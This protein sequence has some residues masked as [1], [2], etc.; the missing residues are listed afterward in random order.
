ML[1]GETFVRRHHRGGPNSLGSGDENRIEASEWHLVLP[2][3]QAPLDVV[4]TRG[5][6]R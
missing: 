1:V 6:E 5:D 2:Q 3:P 4:L